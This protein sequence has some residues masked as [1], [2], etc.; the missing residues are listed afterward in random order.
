[1]DIGGKTRQKIEEVQKV[2]VVF[3]TYLVPD[4]DV[5]DF[6]NYIM[7]GTSRRNEN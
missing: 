4:L 3:K 6:V 7:C 5:L 2:H 1:M